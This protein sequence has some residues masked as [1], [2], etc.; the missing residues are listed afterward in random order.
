MRRRDAQGRKLGP[1]PACST[2]P[3]RTGI[4]SR[5]ARLNS[6]PCAIRQPV[7]T[8]PHRPRKHLRGRPTCPDRPA[9]REVP[10][11]RSR[12][13]TSRLHVRLAPSTARADAPL[14]NLDQR[15][16]T[17]RRPPPDQG[18]GRHFH[19][20]PCT[21]TAGCPRPPS[22]RPSAGPRCASTWSLR[23][24]SRRDHSTPTR[25]DPRLAKQTGTSRGSA[26]TRS[27]SSS[28]CTCHRPQQATVGAHAPLP[29]TSLRPAETPRFVRQCIAELLYA[30]AGW[31]SLEAQGSGSIMPSHA[32]GDAEGPKGT[33]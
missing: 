32:A 12:R 29:V 25:P 18:P 26:R 11:I 3:R 5:P 17:P 6:R 21:R 33:G 19:R 23:N 24:R 8:S 31:A 22:R 10:H 20:S 14:S 27:P 13:H 15:A 30:I 7:T 4:T 28:G 9:M 2:A 16:P 1:E